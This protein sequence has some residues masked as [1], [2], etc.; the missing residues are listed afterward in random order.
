MVKHKVPPHHIIKL[1]RKAL[2]RLLN[3]AKIILVRL[4]VN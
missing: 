1:L 4:L 2:N 3:K